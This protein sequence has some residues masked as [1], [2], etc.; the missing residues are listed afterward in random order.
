MFRIKSI[1][2][3]GA[4]WYYAEQFRD[5]EWRVPENT[6]NTG[7]TLSSQA[8]EEVIESKWWGLYKK[9]TYIYLPPKRLGFKS[10]STLQYMIPQII[11]RRSDN[12]PFVLQDNGKYKLD[13]FMWY[14][15]G[16]INDSIGDYSYESLSNKLYFSETPIDETCKD[17]IN[18]DVLP[19]LPLVKFDF[20]GLPSDF[21]KKYPFIESDKFIMMGEITQMPGH[22]VVVNYKTG[23]IYS[24]FHTDN[25]VLLDDD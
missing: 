24:G 6:E 11:Y 12:A 23:Q 21:H 1:D 15:S 22:C 14:G 8:V 25:F 13:P 7:N 3:D 9:K 16:N 19:K 10:R 18:S 20:R 17:I 5:G 2:T 4:G